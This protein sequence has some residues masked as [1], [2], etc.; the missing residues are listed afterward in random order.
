VQAADHHLKE[1]FRVGW[2]SLIIGLVVFVACLV[3]SQ[4]AATIVA[5]AMV[6]R[7]LEESL[8]IVRWGRQLAAD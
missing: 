3:L 4:V 5:N 6:A 8:I 2:R 1:L 7:V